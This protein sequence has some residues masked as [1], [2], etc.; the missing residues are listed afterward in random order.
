MSSNG[1]SKWII[2]FLQGLKG[3][4]LAGLGVQHM[5]CPSGKDVFLFLGCHVSRCGC[6]YNLN[7]DFL[8]CG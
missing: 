3:C 1:S 8:V 2:P 4:S 5:H 7:L 6:P